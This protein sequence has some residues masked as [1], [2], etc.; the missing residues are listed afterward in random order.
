MSGDLG[1]S[2][3]GKR[4]AKRGPAQLVWLSV[5]FCWLSL[6]AMVC[7]T[8]APCHCRAAGLVFTVEL[9]YLVLKCFKEEERTRLKKNQEYKINK[10]GFKRLAGERY[11]HPGDHGPVALAHCSL[12]RLPPRQPRPY[13]RWPALVLLVI[14]ENGGEG[15]KQQVA[16]RQRQGDGIWI[17]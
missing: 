10:T 11:T 6:S 2:Q 1:K 13:S 16:E 14:W 5:I 17:P 8:R 4:W 9:A 7:P 12:R 3:Y 15:E